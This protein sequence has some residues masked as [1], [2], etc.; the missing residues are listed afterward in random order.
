MLVECDRGI[1]A[2]VRYIRH[3]CI[4]ARLQIVMLLSIV[5]VNGCGP[6][7]PSMRWCVYEARVFENEV[8]RITVLETDKAISGHTYSSPVIELARSDVGTVTIRLYDEPET[9]EVVGLSTEGKKTRIPL[10]LVF[11]GPNITEFSGSDNT[12]DLPSTP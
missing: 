12:G 5:G 7:D 10:Q 1:D 4:A 2:G 3:L 6:V 11:K 8:I 9:Y